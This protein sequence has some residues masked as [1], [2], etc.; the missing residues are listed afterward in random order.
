MA[1]DVSPAAGQERYDGLAELDLG[2][3]LMYR[4]MFCVHGVSQDDLGGNSLVNPKTSLEERFEIAI[5]TRPALS[6]TVHIRAAMT[7]H[8]PLWSPVGIVVTGGR[9]QYVTPRSEGTVMLPGGLRQTPD[10]SVDEMRRAFDAIATQ[11]A[12]HPGY[13]LHNEVVVQNPAI[14][15]LFFKDTAGLQPQEIH[16][17][18][19]VAPNTVPGIVRATSQRFGL[20]VFVIR[21]TGVYGISEWDRETGVYDF[22]TAVR[23]SPASL[24]GVE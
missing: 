14:A 24:V 12:R 17:T 5:T 4:G 2:E 6:S 16:P 19:A 3:E 1:E 15:G 18:V 13:P 21:H 20:P 7:N 11:D 9:V 22:S 23:V 10:Q 8:A